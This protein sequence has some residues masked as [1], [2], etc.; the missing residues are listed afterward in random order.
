M[1][2]MRINTPVRVIKEVYFH[3]SKGSEGVIKYLY[4]PGEYGT[5]WGLLYSVKFKD[6]QQVAFREYELEEIDENS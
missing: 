3:T 4:P 2:L 5:G 1:F 6:N